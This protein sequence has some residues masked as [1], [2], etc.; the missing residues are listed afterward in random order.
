MRPEPVGVSILTN[1]A[2]LHALK[3]CLAS[4]LENCCYRPL[5]VAVFDNGSTDG[6]LEWVAREHP[7]CHAVT[8]EWDR[9]DTDLGCSRGT[10]LACEMTR[11][12][13]HSL[14]LESDFYCLSSAE[15]GAPRTWMRD[16]LEYMR[17][18]GCGY[19]YLRR[20]RDERE[21]Q[22]HFWSQWMARCS[23]DGDGRHMSCPGFWW[24]Q[25]PHLR[26][27]EMLWSSGTLPVPEMMDDHKGSPSWN[28][29]EM[30]AKP[31]PSP[32]LMRW[33][34]FVHDDPGH[35]VAEC[36]WCGRER[37]GWS[38]C[39]YGF[40]NQ[41]AGKWCELCDSSRGF[42]DMAAHEARLRASCVRA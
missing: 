13:K 24:S 30:M 3:R 37:F 41:G 5:H 11:E 29:S 17:R 20:I 33:G 39:K 26:D 8:W 12:F 6:T 16:G 40:Y 4:L 35:R 14:Y 23:L 1:G 2:R 32:S 10:N 28:K 15:S 34:V 22:M 21:M 38:A 7:S 36:S 19:L 31:P 25:N 27:N 9:S 42:E 18:S